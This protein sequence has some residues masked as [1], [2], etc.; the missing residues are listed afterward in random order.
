MKEETETDCLISQVAAVRE[1][2]LELGEGFLA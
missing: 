1:I 2:I